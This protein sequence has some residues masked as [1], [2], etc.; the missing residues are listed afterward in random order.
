MANFIYNELD[1]FKKEFKNLK[2]KYPSLKHDL[3][4]IKL[5]IER[6][7]KWYW[8]NIVQ[9]SNL[10]EEIQIPI[11]KVRKF[12]CKSLQNNKSIRL[13]YAYKEDIN[14]IDLIQIDLVEIYNKST[15]EN[16]NIERIQKYY[17]KN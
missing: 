1:E 8:K 15:K 3:D 11:M 9:M 17:W 16:H 7:P 4:I 5:T 2:K 6:F 10:W 12:P 14:N 13:I